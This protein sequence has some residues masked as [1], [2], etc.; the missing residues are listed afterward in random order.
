MILGFEHGSDNLY[1]LK[2]AVLVGETETNIDNIKI[3]DP[4]MDISLVNISLYK[5][6]QQSSYK[7]RIKKH[8]M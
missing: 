4:N 7:G 5:F 1:H 2:V 8:T 3:L 6:Q